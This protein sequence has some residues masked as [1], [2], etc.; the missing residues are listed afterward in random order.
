[1]NWKT[2]QTN[3]RDLFITGSDSFPMNQEKKIKGVF[4]KRYA[5]GGNKVKKLFLASRSKSRSQGH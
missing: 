4:V 3:G 2:E 5:P 1:M